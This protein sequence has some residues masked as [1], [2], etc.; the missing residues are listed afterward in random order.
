MPSALRIILTAEE[1]RT[2]LELSCADQVPRRTKQRAIALRLNA[3]GWNVPQIAEY[4]DWA[5]QT[6]RQTIKRWQFQGL[7]G[8]WEAA[9]RGKKRSWD[10]VDWQVV[11]KCL[12]QNRRYSARQL[13]Q[14]LFEE[15]QIELGA[16]QIRRLLKK[17]GG[18]G[19][20]SATVRL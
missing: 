10:E 1:D 16:E 4:L 18:V 13:S 12:E 20:V 3:H 14:K 19:N 8:L 5:Q 17:R 6:V 2:L 11:E 7:G 9:G 15:R